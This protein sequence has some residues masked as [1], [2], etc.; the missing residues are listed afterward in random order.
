[1]T[2]VRRGFRFAL[3]TLDVL[4]VFGDIGAQETQDD[5]AIKLVVERSVDIRSSAAADALA[6]VETLGDLDHD[7]SVMQ[8]RYRNR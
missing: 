3:E 4:L 5:V 1:M 2:D 8:E 6:Q 7:A